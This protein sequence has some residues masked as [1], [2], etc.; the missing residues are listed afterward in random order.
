[1]SVGVPEHKRLTVLRALDKF[2]RLGASGVRALLGKG[3]RDQSGDFTPGADLD[4]SQINE[5]MMIFELNPQFRS[6]LD[7]LAEWEQRDA[8]FSFVQAD[9]QTGHLV[10]EI[11]ANLDPERRPS[12]IAKQSA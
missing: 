9:A 2:D 11:F 8:S 4:E 3:R 5:M 6:N 7:Q 1:M 10:R 12:I